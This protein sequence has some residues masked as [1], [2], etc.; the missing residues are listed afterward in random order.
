MDT[1]CC[2]LIYSLYMYNAYKTGCVRVD[3]T[4][5]W[6]PIFDPR[7]EDYDES[8][9]TAAEDGDVVSETVKD[10]T[11]WSDESLAINLD[12]GVSPDNDGVCGVD[13]YRCD[14][15]HCCSSAGY[16]GPDFDGSG[17]IDWGSASDGSVYYTN[18]ADAYAAYCTN[19]VGDWR[20]VA[21]A[22]GNTE[23]YDG[24]SA[25]HS[26][27]AVLSFILSIVVFVNV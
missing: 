10:T 13:S 5:H 9:V 26:V 22:E 24:A 16:C 25:A 21:C 20:V 8:D 12:K 1:V 17:Y 14:T 23:L 6:T 4:T 19:A 27:S 3:D 18:A 15:G 7:K 11:C 2:K